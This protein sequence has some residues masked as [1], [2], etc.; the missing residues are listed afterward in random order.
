MVRADGFVGVAAIIQEHF[1]LVKAG[2]VAWTVALFGL[3]SSAA[4][5][6]V[7]PRQVRITWLIPLLWFAMTWSRIRHGPLFVIVAA[8]AVGEMYPSIR[9]REWLVRL[10]SVSCRLQTPAVV[11]G[12]GERWK[13]LLLPVGVVLAA[14]VLEASSV[15][16]P[17]FGRGSGASGTG[18]FTCRASAGAACLR[19][20][21]CGGDAH[22]QRYAVR[23]ISH[24]LHSRSESIRR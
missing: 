12:L 23:G 1:P 5:V 3:V 21:S 14:F 6:G 18:G 2:A 7:E 22:F 13:P 16:V 17:L 4:L 11:A 15:R 24:L 20:G 9:W 10:G 8:L 19:E